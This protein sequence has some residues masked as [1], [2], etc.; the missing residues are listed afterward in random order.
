MPT[1]SVCICTYK[2]PRL[3]QRLLRELA[4][5]ETAGALTFSIVV[6]DN[7]REES[8]KG[9]VSEFQESSS[10]PT[11]YCVEVEQNIALTRNR[12]LENARGDFVAFIDDDEF[13][14]TD[15]LVTLMRTCEA[16]GV[17][18]VLGPVRPFFEQEPPQW[19]RRGRFCE[20]PEHKTGSLL[21][22]RETRTG[23]V[24]FRRRII[25]GLREPFRRALGNGGE[26]QDFFK[27]MI[28]KGHK[29]VW[30]NEASVSEVVPPQRWKRTYF[31]RRALLRG[32]NER[33]SLTFLSVGKSVIAVPIYAVLLPFLLLLGHH[34]FMGN[35]IKLMDHAG[36]LFAA[37]GLKPLGEK[38]LN[39]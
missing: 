5:Q 27:R 13:P 28:E 29:F 4:R 39:R 7:D 22:W 14:A 32:Q 35:L 36:K 6:A 38:Y 31:L 8:A 16:R 18:G 1:V 11:I 34:R 10:I 24:L 33:H 26:D 12:A 20:R 25:E 23:N 2:R 21:S 30:C 17:D 37:M 3:L 19:L 9:V 15:W